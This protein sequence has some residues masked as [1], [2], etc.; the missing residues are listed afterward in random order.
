MNLKRCDKIGYP[1]VIPIRAWFLWS[2]WGQFLFLFLFFS[3]IFFPTFRL[4]IF[5]LPS[6]STPINHQHLNLNIIRTPHSHLV[7]LAS[8]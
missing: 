2:T 7:A 8:Y 6:L 3:D 1:L 4:L 5:A